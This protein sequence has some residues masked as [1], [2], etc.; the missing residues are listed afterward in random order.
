MI[1]EIKI[2]L[3]AF[4]LSNHAVYQAVNLHN[5]PKF[6]MAYFF[7]TVMNFIYKYNHHN[8]IIQVVPFS[9]TVKLNNS[10][11]LSVLNLSDL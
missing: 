6:P 4:Q 11:N 7:M 1:L 9:N 3:N 8:I 2:I 5:C 10:Q